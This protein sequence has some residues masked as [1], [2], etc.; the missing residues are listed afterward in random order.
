MTPA[1]RPD[2]FATLNDE[3]RAAVEHGLPGQPGGP[4]LVIAGAGTGKTMTLAARV[5]RLVLAGADPNRILMLTFSRRAAQEMAR[6]VGRLLHTALG[7]GATQRAPELPWSGTFHAIGARLLREHADAIGLAPQFTI[8]DRGDAE[9]L[10]GWA[11]QEQGLAS[12]H[13]RFPLKGTCLALYSRVVNSRLSLAEVVDAVFPWCRGHEAALQQLFRA[14]VEA[15]Q[16]QHVLDYDDLLL[17]WHG[18]LGEPA[19]AAALGRRFEHVLVD[20]YQDTNRLQA[21]ILLALKPDGRGLTVVGDDAQSIYAFRAAEV[22]NI[23][24]FPRPL[25][26][27]GAHRHADAQLPL[28]AAD[29]RGLERGDRARRRTLHEGPL[30]RPRRPAPAP[31]HGGGRDGPGPPRRRRGAAATRRRADADEPGGAVPHRRTTVRPSSS[32]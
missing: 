8:L 26:A 14:Y 24:D 17:Y 11:R 32:S 15:K 31:R 3:Q 25:R 5:A 18:M 22:R 10:M 23:L 2:P 19:I 12:A 9:D 7:F 28:D 20:E 13:Q 30:E 16:Q 4:L 1:S 6:R 27:A 29:P 21:E